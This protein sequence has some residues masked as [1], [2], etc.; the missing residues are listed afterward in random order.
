MIRPLIIWISTIV[1]FIL[2]LY[3]KRHNTNWSDI[4]IGLLAFDIL[5]GIAAWIYLVTS[6][7][8]LL[9]KKYSNLKA[10]LLSVPFLLFSLIAGVAIISLFITKFSTSNQKSV[11]AVKEQH[12]NLINSGLK[13]GSSGE[14]VKILQSALAKDKSIYPSG[15]VSGYYGNLTQDAVVNF[16]RKYSIKESG[17]MDNQTTEKFNEVYGIQ[18]RSYY[19]SLYPTNIPAPIY[20]DKQANT[21]DTDPIIDCVSSYPNCNGSSIRAPRSQCSK[22]TCCQVGTNWSVYATVEKCNEAQ[23][24]SQPKQ[25]T[26]PQNTTKTQGNNVYCWNNAYG[27]GYYT[28]SGDQCNLDN[29]KLGTYKICMDSQKMKSDSC[30]STCKNT[31]NHDNDICAWAYTGSNAGIEQNNDKYGE[32]LNGPGGSGE[33]YSTCL[34]KCTEQ[35]TQDIKQCAN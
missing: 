16:Q 8:K 19:L 2:I 22:I 28:S 29:A 11:T 13:I 7:D 20:F 21:S 12:Y 10:T 5:G 23:N 24:N 26:A 14:D 25:Q 18:T 9:H 6:F 1:L 32:C 15:S 3:S 31:L 4:E 35:Y 30:N 33:N 34:G 27:Y 17:V